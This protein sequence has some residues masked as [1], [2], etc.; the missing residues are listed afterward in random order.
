MSS[1]AKN[2]RSTSRVTKKKTTGP[3]DAAPKKAEKGSKYEY[4]ELTKAQ[5]TSVTAQHFYAVVID[6]TFPYK[7]NQE[8]Y[9]CSLKIVDPSLYLKKEKGTGDNSDYAT[10]VLY[11][12]RFEDL[13]IIHR[14]GD[15]IR[16]HRA[17]IRLYNGQRQFN[18]NIFYSSSWA[19]FST[20][21]KSALQ[22]IGGQEATS[23]L[24]PFSHSGKNF[25][26]QKNEAGIVQ[27]I[28]KWAQQY[29]TQ[30]SVIS[31]DMFT[32][33]NKAQ[34][35]KGD[36]DVV[37]KILQIHELDEY[38]NEL[39]LKDASGQVFY[40]LALKLK[41]P[42][43]RTGEV[44]RIRSATYDE[45]STQKKV[46][47]LSHYSNIVTFI[48]TSKLAKELRGKITDDRAVEK[49]ALKQDV[50]LSAV[51]L[52]EVDKKHAG[53]PAHSL[54]DL[55][56]NA[57]S[58]KELSSKD[59]F[60]TQFYVT[61]IEPSDVKEWVKAYDRKTKKVTSLKGSA[62]KGGDNIFQVSFLVKDASTQLNNNTYRVLLYTHDGL[63]ANFFNG[64]KADNLH[65][66]ADARKK[67][68]EYSE[69]LTRFNS[70]VDA[71]V[72]RRNGFYFIKDTRIVY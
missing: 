59:T 67:L 34:A 9:I 12:K 58:D 26:F 30:Y 65:K 51:V 70:Y 63:G 6:A 33:L 46:L 50:S 15:I 27:N 16:I 19:L 40:T 24:V 57:D 62:A 2:Q 22:E 5:L 48:S 44:V 68:E 39:K 53:L 37:A 25:T 52:T 36:F 32:A 4:V 43:L 69:L 8:R 13:P 14:L 1:A 72:E 61:K 56:H 42:H 55:F 49:A 35:Q 28:R 54:H 7:T 71:V 31:N 21:K 23:D 20:D 60:R 66:N 38:T 11:A 41:F 29:F 3:K 10:L 47:L 18:A 17:T 45:T 64:V